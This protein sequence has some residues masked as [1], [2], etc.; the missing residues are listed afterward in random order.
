MIVGHFWAIT[1]IHFF[2]WF[3]CNYDP[4]PIFFELSWSQSFSKDRRSDW[5]SFASLKKISKSQRM[6]KF[7]LFD[8]ILSCIASTLSFKFAWKQAKWTIISS[9][10]C[11]QFWG[12]FQ[13]QFK[14][15]QKDRRSFF[16][17]PDRSFF[18]AIRSRSW[19]PIQKKC[20]QQSYVHC[21]Y[22][23]Y[24]DCQWTPIRSAIIDHWMWLW[25]PKNERNLIVITIDNCN[26]ILI[27]VMVNAISIAIIDQWSAIRSAIISNLWKNDLVMF[28]N[29]K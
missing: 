20:D 7:Y 18:W 14:W 9:W 15:L 2:P 11:E 19:S 5:R 13:W 4:D 1:I 23:G 26:Q 17:D 29:T 6:D 27:Y 3:N 22:T 8:L 10:I 12:F 25:L 21:Q 16:K 24:I 28:S